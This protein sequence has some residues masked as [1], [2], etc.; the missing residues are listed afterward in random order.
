MTPERWQQVKKLFQSAIS[1][2]TAERYN[3][4]NAACGGDESLRKE[5]ESLIAS[6]ERTGSFID[7]PALM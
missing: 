6:H 1:L 5:V 2:E 4:L 7:S 3:F